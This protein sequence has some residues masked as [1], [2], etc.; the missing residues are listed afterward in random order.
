G[1]TATTPVVPALLVAN[2]RRFPGLTADQLD[3]AGAEA[4]GRPWVLT[5]PAPEGLSPQDSAVTVRRWH[6]ALA[7]LRRYDT[8]QT[9]AS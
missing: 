6:A 1:V 8:L 2:P 5:F 4:S 3:A 7:L 9:S